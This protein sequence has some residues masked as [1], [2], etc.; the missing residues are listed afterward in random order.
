MISSS[1]STVLPLF[2]AGLRLTDEF[3][4]LEEPLEVPE[5]AADVVFPADRPVLP[6]LKGELGPE[7]RH[8]S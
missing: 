1:S 4:S 5:F 8:K 7:T 3:T 2:F 6:D